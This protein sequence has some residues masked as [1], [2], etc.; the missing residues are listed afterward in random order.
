MTQEISETSQKLLLEIG[1]NIRRT[2]DLNTIWQETV[3]GLR[4]AT[5]ASRCIICPLTSNSAIL[6]VVAECAQES[7][8]SMLGWEIQ[9]EAEPY[10]SQAQATKDVVV[11]DRLEAGSQGGRQSVLAVASRYQDKPNAVISL[12]YCDGQGRWSDEDLEFVREVADMAGSAIAHANLCQELQSAQQQ[13]KEA[14]SLKSQFLRTINDQILNPLN[15]IIGPLKL[16]LD[17][18]MD[19]AAEERKFIQDA[20]G[21]ALHLYEMINDILTFKTKP[22]HMQLELLPVNFNKLLRDVRRY[23]LDQ[24]L[25]KRLYLNIQ[26]PA[27]EILVC[28]DYRGL[29]KVMLYLAGNAIKFTH[30]GGVTIS[31][32]VFKQRA[33]VHDRERPGIVE[34]R[35]SDTGIGVPVEYQRRLFE[36]FFRVHASTTS[37]YPGS[38]LGLAISKKLVEAMGG[39]IHF[40]SMGEGLGS[41]VSFT[42]PLY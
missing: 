22:A 35:V 25:N 38:G 37:P 16:I 18:Q 20:Y 27:D 21:S 19:D 40:Y 8:S 33:I 42:V 30:L 31:A 32:E 29:L 15:G 4:P 28:A 6:P 3:R 26:M 2:R 7:V 36:P 13:L 41:T 17:D 10:L 34:V 9:L 11:A 24:V 23:T 1:R 5:G 39:E 12:H 14:L